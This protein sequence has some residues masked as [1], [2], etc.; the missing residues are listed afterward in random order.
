[1]LLLVQS[2]AVL[3]LA[4]TGKG[5]GAGS[6]VT[7]LLLHTVGQAGLLGE[8]VSIE[9]HGSSVPLFDRVPA[10]R[11]LRQT[12]RHRRAPNAFQG[13]G[14][15]PVKL[16]QVLALLDPFGQLELPPR[17]LRQFVAAAI[18]SEGIGELAFRFNT[19]PKWV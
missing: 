6:V 16:D 11:E 5:G 13:P 17:S 19:W 4:T 12:P 7:V 1:M 18:R 8:C 3:A 9:A 15:F 10:D 2:I 14:Q